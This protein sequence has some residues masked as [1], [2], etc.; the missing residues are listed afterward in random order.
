MDPDIVRRFVITHLDIALL[1]NTESDVVTLDERNALRDGIEHDLTEGVILK[2]DLAINY[3]LSIKSVDAL[4]CSLGTKAV[5]HNDFVC[6]QSYEDQLSHSILNC[7]TVSLEK[8][9]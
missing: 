1:N 2:S 7:I 8:L 5:Y 3:D 4:L 6:S 9:E